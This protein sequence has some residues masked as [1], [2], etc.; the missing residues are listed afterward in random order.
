MENGKIDGDPVYVTEY[1]NTK[2]DNTQETGEYRLEMGCWNY[3]AANQHG[4]V[5]FT[6]DPLTLASSNETKFVLHTKWSLT[7]LALANAFK[8]FKLV[9]APA[10]SSEL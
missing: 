5:R 7:N 8:I 6:I 9:E 10:S 2:A 1:I 4:E 3:L